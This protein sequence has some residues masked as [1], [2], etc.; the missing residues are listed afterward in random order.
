MNYYPLFIKAKLVI[1]TVLMLIGCSGISPDGEMYNHREEG[2]K[3]GLFSGE[4]GEFVIMA[5]ESSKGDD[6]STQ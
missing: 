1:I 4:K 2:T 3:K 6:T 5:P